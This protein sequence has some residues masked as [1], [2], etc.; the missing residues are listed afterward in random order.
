VSD[1]LV[2]PGAPLHG[3]VFLGGRWFDK[4]EHIL[5]RNP[6]TGAVLGSVPLC[7]SE[8]ARLAVGEARQAFPG[9]AATPLDRRLELLEVLSHLVAGEADALASLVTYESGKPIQ[10]AHAVDVLGALDLLR[11]LLREAPRRLRPMGASA[12]NPL[13]WGKRHRVHRVPLGVAA[14]ISPWN[15]PLAIPLGQVVLAL[16]AGNTVVL[17]PSEH[18][19]LTAV[20]LA[21]LFQRAG[22]PPGV[23]NLLTGDGETGAALV[24][25]PV[26]AVLFTGSTA[27]G[28]GIRQALAGR[29]VPALLELGGK[30]AFIVLPDAPWERTLA[31]ALWNGCFGTGQ[32]CSSSER[33]LVPRALA[34]PFAE[35]LAARARTLKM[36]EGI[37]PSTQV[38]PLISEAQRDKVAAQV[39]EARERGARVLCG[40]E[41]PSG[42]G[43]FY[44]PT[45]VVD[46]PAD[47]A[48]LREETFGPVFPILSYQEIDEAVRLCNDSAFGLSASVWT[49]DLRKGEAVAARLEVGSV[50]IN[51]AS[52]THGSIGCPW[53]GVKGS[54]MGRTHWWGTLHDLTHPKLVAVDRGRW[55]RELWWYPYTLES[56]AMVREYRQMLWSRG[57]VRFGHAVR[58]AAAFL[59][60]RE[61]G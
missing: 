19:P 38:G 51:D 41:K 27:T 9:W 33:F 10:E 55:S 1:P 30:D 5:S 32:A 25:A 20:K 4:P 36:G 40:G 35:G 60:G 53:G 12:G 48:L 13:F 3:E 23:F 14:V 50:W 7:N 17:K 11:G 47:C 24:S 2:P 46:P 16:A 34:G 22:F 21:T 61:K 43:F 37:D 31:G 29:L 39:D 42:P 49:A 52:Y 57:V 44:P 6:A 26:D 28:M 8:D 15:L 54:G 45:V 56:L 18:T 59:R 58:A